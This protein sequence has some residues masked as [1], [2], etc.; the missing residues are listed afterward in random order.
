V[1]GSDTPGR[2]GTTWEGGVFCSPSRPQNR[3]KQKAPRQTARRQEDDHAPEF[4][5]AV[6]CLGPQDFCS[7]VTII[8]LVKVARRNWFNRSTQLRRGLSGWKSSAFS[9][10]IALFPGGNLETRV[11]CSR[12]SSSNRFSGRP[13]LLRSLIKPLSSSSSWSFTSHRL[14]S[15][16]RARAACARFLYVCMCP[17]V[18][19]LRSGAATSRSHA[20]AL[21][22]RV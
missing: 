1:E 22:F 9:S 19:P 16:R 14:V 17:R 12:L 7:Q 13:Y 3:L 10:W 6:H 15:S 8:L 18:L 20:L 2:P 4:A 11:V 5:F 21:G